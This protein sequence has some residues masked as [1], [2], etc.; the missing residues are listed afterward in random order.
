MPPREEPGLCGVIRRQTRSG[1]NRSPRPSSSGGS[2][3]AARPGLPMELALERPC[4]SPVRPRTSPPRGDYKRR[5]YPDAIRSGGVGG[6]VRPRR[7][8]G[9]GPGEADRALR[10]ASG[11][12]RATMHQYRSSWETSTR[13]AYGRTAASPKTGAGSLGLPKRTRACF[14][15]RL[16]DRRPGGYAW[17]RVGQHSRKHQTGS[18]G[19]AGNITFLKQ[20]RTAESAAAGQMG[21]AELHPEPGWRTGNAAS[22][23]RG[24]RRSRAERQPSAILLLSTC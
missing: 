17:M 15:A 23:A 8:R 24:A 14:V 7:L 21:R 3:Q 18:S 11:K 22:G 16:C 9:S 12:T 2:R 10:E 13:R 4:P 1:A 20:L 5:S 19:S 6:A